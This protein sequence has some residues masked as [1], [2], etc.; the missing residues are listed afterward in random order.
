MNIEKVFFPKLYRRKAIDR[1]RAQF[2]QILDEN[3][4]S[5]YDNRMF[6]VKWYESAEQP[7]ILILNCIEYGKLVRKEWYEYYQSR[8]NYVGCLKREK[9]IEI[10]RW[11]AWEKNINDFP[12]YDD[13][14]RYMITRSKWSDEE[15][16]EQARRF[17]KIYF[18]QYN[19]LNLEK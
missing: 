11:Q 10:Y 12:N 16:E 13:Y 9:C 18:D 3:S 14:A 19:S 6:E 5:G 1:M 15:T 7:Y 8:W 2:P 17:P 4:C